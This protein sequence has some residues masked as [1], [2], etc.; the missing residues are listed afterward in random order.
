MRRLVVVSVA[1]ALVLVAAGCG[2]SAPEGAVAESTDGAEPVAAGVRVVSE[3][4]VVPPSSTTLPPVTETT[5]TTAPPP[6]TAAAGTY[7]IQPGDTLSVIAEQF[8]VS[9][10][11][12]SEANQ[13]TD[14]NAIQ[15]GQELIIPGAG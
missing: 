1:A 4:T 12:I 15:P 5:T 13:I 3:Q 2:R 8:G 10:Q 6:P 9:V 11:A 7:V 14:V